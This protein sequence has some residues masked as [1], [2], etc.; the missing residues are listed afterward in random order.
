M[1]PEA[2]LHAHAWVRSNDISCTMKG[3]EAFYTTLFEAF[4]P[5]AETQNHGSLISMW[6]KDPCV[7]LQAKGSNEEIPSVPVL[8]VSPNICL[9]LVKKK[10]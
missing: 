4:L 7:L 6:L 10:L 5:A 1:F 8:G 2:I 9:V 3:N